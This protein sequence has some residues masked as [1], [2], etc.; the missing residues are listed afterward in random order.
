MKLDSVVIMKAKETD[1]IKKRNFE[2]REGH[3]GSDKIQSP[4][5]GEKE[6]EIGEEIP[7]SGA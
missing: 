5:E 6:G 7:R 4:W 1:E 2:N 3:R